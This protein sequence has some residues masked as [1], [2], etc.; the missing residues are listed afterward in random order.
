MCQDGQGGRDHERLAYSAVS[1]CNHRATQQYKYIESV[2]L[3]WCSSCPS[4]VPHITNT[5]PSDIMK[6]TLV[7]VSLASM[8]SAS[9][10]GHELFSRAKSQC[11]N[12][13]QN[14]DDGPC[15]YTVTCKSF[16]Q[17]DSGPLAYTTP[18]S[19]SDCLSDC[20]DYGLDN[21]VQCGSVNY[22]PKSHDCQL[23]ASSTFQSTKKNKKYDSAILYG[24]G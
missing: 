19:L 24:C 14:P 3:C 5:C 20:T 7:A 6:F 8:A 1:S 9:T 16:G 10:I 11:T 15:S 17:S 22:N 12:G 4:L 18:T 21:G 23:Y 13:V 2:Y